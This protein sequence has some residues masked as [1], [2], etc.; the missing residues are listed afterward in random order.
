MLALLDATLEELLWR[1]SY[2]AIFHDSWQ[3]GVAFPAVGFGM[4]HL[5]PQLLHL[6][7][8]P[9]GKLSF[10]AVSMVIGLMWGWVAFAAS[11]ILLTSIAHLMFDFS[12]LGAKV[13][14]Q[15]TGVKP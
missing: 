8:A 3:L 13:Y 6:N 7:R 1:G 9:G 10:V 5:S 14:L 12:G 15:D 4:W 2:I 11:S